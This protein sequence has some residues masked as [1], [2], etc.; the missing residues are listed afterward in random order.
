MELADLLAHP[1]Q[2]D[3]QAVAVTGEVSNLQLATNREGQ[4]AYGFLLKA[5][6]G[7][8]KVIGL[9]RTIVQEGEQVVVEGTFNRLRQG[10]RTV[11][12]NEIK[13]DIVRPLARLTPDL[14]G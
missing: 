12:L 6:S 2:Y 11:V 9:G 13:A 10:G 5:S 3:K 4:S 14:I 8:V 1:D 7:T